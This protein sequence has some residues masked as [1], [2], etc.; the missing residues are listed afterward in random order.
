MQVA[1]P[2]LRSIRAPDV[3]VGTLAVAAFGPYVA[4]SVRTDQ[5][6]AYLGALLAAVTWLLSSAPRRRPSRHQ[7]LMLLAWT[8]IPLVATIVWLAHPTRGEAHQALAT[9]DSLLLPVAVAL[10]VWRFATPQNRDRL[11]RV[12]ACV[13]VVALSLNALLALVQAMGVDAAWQDVWLPDGE[14]TVALRAAQNHRFSGVL[15]Q[16]ALASLYY[17]IGM[18]F[19]VHLT[20]H[21]VARSLLFILLGLGVA[22][23]GSKAFFVACLP[24]LALMLLWRQRRRVRLLALTAALALAT[25]ALLLI[26]LPHLPPIPGIS[27]YQVVLDGGFSMATLTSNRLGGSNQTLALMGDVLADS[28]VVGWGL[29]GIQAATDSQLT[30]AMVVAGLVGAAALTVCLAIGWHA[31]AHRRGSVPETTWLLLTGLM[32]VPTVGSLGFP[33]LVGN[34]ISLVLWLSL[35]LLLTTRATAPGRH[36]ATSEEMGKRA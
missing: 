29:A 27:R 5:V 15:N 4:G 17:G 12:V 13:A 19:A 33:I 30:H 20:R 16:P 14:S 3:A 8:L 31:V 24:A 32:I 25:A 11:V 23:T 21:R 9:L 34:R 18:L 10:I 36:A 6:I 26:L 7:A 1:L 28:P 35:M 2:S 22:L